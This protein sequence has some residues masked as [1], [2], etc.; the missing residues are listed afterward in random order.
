MFYKVGFFLLLTAAMLLGLGLSNNGRWSDVF[1]W[2]AF[3]SFVLAVKPL[4]DK[5]YSLLVAKLKGG[6]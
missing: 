6:E 3:L 2:G 1:F 4:W 5:A